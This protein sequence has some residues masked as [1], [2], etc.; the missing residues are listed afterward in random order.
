MPRKRMLSL[1]VGA[2]VVLAVVVLVVAA[3]GGSTTTTTAGPETTMAPE[4]TVAPETTAG[5]TT[6]AA[7]VDAAA[8]Y[9]ANCQ[10]CHS[11]APTGD[12]ATIA[13]DITNGVGSAMPAFADKLSADEITALATYVANGLK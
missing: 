7:S 2:C 3:C 5:P 6:T 8:L 9:S 12:E 11:T 10:G 13:G 1:G 4:T